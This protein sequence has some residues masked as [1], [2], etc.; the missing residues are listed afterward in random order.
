MKIKKL[1]PNARWILSLVVWLA[2]FT[3]FIGGGFLNNIIFG[4]FPL[5]IH[6]II[7]WTGVG[8]TVISAVMDLMN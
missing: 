1:V 5:I 6:Q 2:V 3:S 7:G 8:V 4:W